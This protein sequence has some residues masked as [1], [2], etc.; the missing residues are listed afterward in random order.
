MNNTTIAFVLSITVLIY[1]L[2]NYRKVMLNHYVTSYVTSF[3]P[4]NPEMMELIEKGYSN[5]ILSEIQKIMHQKE[6]FIEKKIF[7]K[8]FA[9]LTIY[10]NTTI[11]ILLFVSNLLDLSMSYAFLFS[12]FVIISSLLVAFIEQMKLYQVKEQNDIHQL[13]SERFLLFLFYNDCNIHDKIVKEGVSFKNF[14]SLSIF[15]EYSSLFLELTRSLEILTD[16]EFRKVEGKANIFFEEVDSEKTREYLK[17]M[18]LDSLGMKRSN[19]HNFNYYTFKNYDF[20]TSV[21]KLPD[22]VNVH[23]KD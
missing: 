19:Y 16:K 17:D 22:W 14:D 10:V 7:L 23:M 4:N 13:F 8:S 20:N 3:N 5:P 6:L 1:M 12:L 9:R 21:F 11:M 18:I 15:V 2:I